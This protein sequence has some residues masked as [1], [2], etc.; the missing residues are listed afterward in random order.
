VTLGVG[1]AQYFL[2]LF[3]GTRQS[4]DFFLDGGLGLLEGMEKMM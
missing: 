4:F 3:S 1:L 2:R